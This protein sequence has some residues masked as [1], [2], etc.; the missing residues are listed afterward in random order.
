MAKTNLNVSRLCDAIRK[1]RLALRRFR[2]ERVSIVRQ[3][4]GDHWSEEGARD[5]VPLNLIA[6]YCNIISRNLIAKNPR[7]MLSTFDRASRG[8][9]AAEGLWVNKEIE[10][11]DLSGTLRRAVLDALIG[12]PGIVKVALAAPP[13]VAV[14]SWRLSPGQ[15]FAETIDLDDFVFDSHARDFRE[16]GFLGHRYRVPLDSVRDSRVYS[17]ARKDLS[18]AEDKFYNAEGDERIS[19]L[20]REYYSNQEEYEDM[21]DLWEIYLPGK[22]LILTLADQDLAGPDVEPLRVQDWIGPD[23]GPYHLLSLLTVPGNCMPKSPAQD[24]VDLHLAVNNCLRKLI[25]QAQ[26]LKQNIFV[27]GGADEDGQRVMEASDGQILKVDNPQNISA[28]GSVLAPNQQLFAL[29]V[30]LKEMF[31]WSAGNLDMLGGL[32]PQSHTATQDELLAKSA[33]GQVTDM[34]EITLTF[35][36]EVVKS[37][38]WYWHRHPTLNM[39]ADLPIPGL[40]GRSVRRT[41]SPQDRA[42]T[43]LADLDVRVDPYSL[44]HQTPEGRLQTM[45]TV[46]QQVVLP[47]AQLMVQQGISLDLAAY[48]TKIG[49]LTDDPDLSDIL[50]VVEPPQ[51]NEAPGGQPGGAPPGAPPVGPQRRTYE[52]VSR[53]ART[54]GGTAMDLAQTLMKGSPGSAQ[55]GQMRPGMGQ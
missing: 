37:L 11:M 3:Y 43:R 25:R 26:D 42:G 33:G 40:E 13:D 31:T 20:G 52:R 9:V 22:R 7:V 38:L 4:V 5:P 41:L 39:R 28:P 18:P 55:N 6:M 8:V 14:S 34:Q 35:T 46:V 48:L 15:P 2:E 27:A 21:V 16:A 53:S 29:M 47:L 24:L 23:S 12:G 50:T 32:S 36:S 51:G 49:K 54:P 19:V 17:K 45:Q 44:R 30:A 10:A 1:S